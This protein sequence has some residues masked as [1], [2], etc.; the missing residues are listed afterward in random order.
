MLGLGVSGAH[1]IT[2][3]DPTNPNNGGINAK[4]LPVSSTY[5]PGGQLFLS[6]SY[7]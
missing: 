4:D 2:T 5:V 6:D 1:A 7:T 3:F